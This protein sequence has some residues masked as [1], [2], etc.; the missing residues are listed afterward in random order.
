[1]PAETIDSPPWWQQIPGGAATLLVA[2]LTA[3]WTYVRWLFGINARVATL[4]SARMET[5]RLLVETHDA[6][7]ETRAQLEMLLLRK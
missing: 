2:L 5:T 3:V 6:V 1:M 4:E 7:I